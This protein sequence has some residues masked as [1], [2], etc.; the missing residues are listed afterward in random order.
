MSMFKTIAVTNRHLCNGS[1][2]EQIN[3]IAKTMRPDSLIL[4]EKDLPEEEYETLA[5]KV[6]EGCRRFELEC[7]LHTYTGVAIRLKC[8][9]IHLSVTGLTEN[10]DR[11]KFFDE[12]GVSVHSQDEAVWAEK[13]GATYL[14]VGHIFETNCKQGVP[15]RGIEFLNNVCE[16]VTIPVY[17]IGGINQKNSSLLRTTGASG[18]CIMSEFMRKSN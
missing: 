2:V 4:R 7:I 8:K 9:K 10:K 3:M 16:N 12:I 17:A 11:L 14:M 13:N 5:T 15:P 6:M 1:L 18:V